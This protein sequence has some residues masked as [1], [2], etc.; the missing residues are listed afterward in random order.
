MAARISGGRFSFSD[1]IF[2]KHYFLLLL[3]LFLL[4]TC[5]KEKETPPYHIQSLNKCIKSSVDNNPQKSSAE[6]AEFKLK[7]KKILLND[8]ENGY[9]QFNNVAQTFITSGPILNPGTDSSKQYLLKIGFRQPA[10][11]PSPG[12]PYSLPV[13]ESDE[14]FITLQK[15]ENLSVVEFIDKHLLVGELKLRQKP[16]WDNTLD[17]AL[18]DGFEINYWC[19]HCCRENDPTPGQFAFA[20][21]SPSQNGFLRCTKLDRVDLGEN[22]S[23]HIEFEFACELYTKGIFLS[24]SEPVYELVGNIENG[25]MVVDFVVEK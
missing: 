23:Y 13:P 25:K 7:G 20:S 19:T 9:Q 14:F 4:V 17:P 16:W 3:T 22:V 5:E 6:F 12:Q 8:G 15:K 18:E 1:N 2:M 21:S 24:D 11:T 10:P